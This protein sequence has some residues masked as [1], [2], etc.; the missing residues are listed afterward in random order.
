M[1]QP[2]KKM[3]KNVS[4]IMRNVR[5][6]DTA[7]ELV[8]RKALWAKGLRY[9]IRPANLIGKPD[10]VITSKRLAIFID[11]DYWHGGQWR[12]RNLAALE[13]QFSAT[14]SKD[15]WLGKI[16]RNMDRDCRTTTTLVSEGWIV[17]RFWESE[18]YKNLG[19]CVDMTLEIARQDVEPTPFSLAPQKTFA[20]FFAGIGLMRMGL[21]R[22][23]WSIKFANDIDPQKYE[24]YKGQFVDAENHSVLGDIHEIPIERVPRVTLATASFPCNDLS[25]AGSR[26]GLYGKQ[27]S[28]FWGFIRI[29]EGMGKWRPP[30][31][32]LENVLGFLT[33]RNGKDFKE[34]LIALNRLGYSVDPFILD[35]ARFV[36]QSRQ[37]LFVVGVLE[38]HS[39][40]W[41]VRETL[42]FYES[43]VRPKALAD[44]IFT[45]PE[46]RW[47]IRDLPPQPKNEIRLETIIE[48]I[49]EDSLEWWS[50][51]RTEYLLNQ[52]SHRHREMAEQ[53]IAGG[54]WSYGTV[55][56]RVR[57]GKSMAELR[58]D[59]LAGCLRTPRGGSGRQIL[60][61]AG[62]GRCFARLL[63]PRECARLM[64]ADEYNISVPMN[65]ALFGFG[66]AVCVPVI[67]WIAKYYLNPL[68]NE[69]LRGRPLFAPM[70]GA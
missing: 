41:E 5:S 16:R 12:R 14:S 34:A 59:G 20:E 40:A 50:P 65:Q 4:A 22:Q 26:N 33:S 48:D 36:P 51:E 37:R 31:I 21:E 18:I 58:T 61:K 42:R 55:F 7:P 29:L 53:M 2:E 28:A 54:E 43:D 10:I 35:A 30:I 62:K 52:M 27:S 32:L 24:M 17:L 25:L 47:R 63:T 44:Y 15:Y 6:G 67:E 23:G 60:F 46:I 39:A 13:D 1:F 19:R 9:R 66:D 64:G 56:R 45:H 68:V 38:E 3:E 70:K 57:N 8:F 49:P 11:G 69:L